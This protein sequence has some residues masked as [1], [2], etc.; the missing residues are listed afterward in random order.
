MDSAWWRDAVFYQIYPRSFLDTNG[1]GIGDLEGVRRGLAHVAALGADAVWLSPFFASPMEDFGYDVSDYRAVDPIFGTMADF[2]AVLEEAHRLGLKLVIDQVYSH[3]SDRHAWFQESRRDR[4]NEKADWYV[5][6]DA[7]PDGTPPNNW[8]SVFGG[9]AWTWDARRRQYYL[10]NFLS[11]QPDLNF[12]CEAVQEA[13]LETARFW[14]D[15]GVDGFRLDVANFYYCDAQLRDNPPAGNAPAARPHRSQHHL[16]D[17][18]QPETLDFLARLRAVTDEYEGRMMVA[19]VDSTDPEGRSIEYTDGPT[20]LHTAYSFSFLHSPALSPALV[21]RA[22]T[23]WEGHEAWPS[24]SFSNHDVARVASRWGGEERP[25]RA[26]MLNAL[27]LCLRGT[28]F[29]YQGEELGLPQAEVPFE[30]LRDPEAIRFYPEG[31]GRDGCRTPLPWRAD[32][33][34]G[35]FSEAEPWLPFDERHGPLAID[36]Q[37]E[38]EGSTLAITRRLIAL[39]KEE[40][41]LRRGS[42]EFQDAEDPLLVFLR[43]HEGDRLLCAF[44]LSDREAG[45]TGS[46]VSGAQSLTDGLLPG[47]I[48]GDHLVLPPDGG[49]IARLTR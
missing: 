31:L 23:R 43:E 37:A 17:R 3:S 16:Y 6:A 30:R 14:L 28:P 48:D 46:L 26:V 35:G 24:W 18:S 21:R 44:N 5:W 39:R 8:L 47:L 41:A 36:R 49:L 27:L 45:Y 29:L 33:P 7:K 38:D 19:E 4:T 9:P 34:H 15:K 22:L 10:H 32:A 1:D 42:L 11:S 25:G 40:A 20:R 2:D 12:R 13:I